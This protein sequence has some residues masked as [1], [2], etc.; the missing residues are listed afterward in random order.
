[1]CVCVCV[2][3]H[4][5]THKTTLKIT[6]HLHS[7]GRANT[8]TRLSVR[9]SVS[10]RPFLKF[11]RAFPNNSIKCRGG[12]VERQVDAL[13]EVPGWSL[14]DGRAWNQLPASVRIVTTGLGVGIS[15]RSIFD[16]MLMNCGP[17]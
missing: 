8:D 9:Q 15:Q 6:S 16:S 10:K 14:W 4:G 2:C 17:S 12:W 3:V 13:A 11:T 7:V 1:V 5:T